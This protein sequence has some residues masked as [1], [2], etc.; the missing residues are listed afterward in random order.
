MRSL[1][2]LQ[3]AQGLLSCGEK[4]SAF[5]AVHPN[6]LRQLLEHEGEGVHAHHDVDV[7]D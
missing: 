5:R 6:D 3:N 4:M 7:M 2:L 1:G